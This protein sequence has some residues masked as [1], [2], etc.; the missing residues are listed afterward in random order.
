MLPSPFDDQPGK[1]VELLRF[2]VF[3][4][5]EQSLKAPRWVISCQY[6]YRRTIQDPLKRRSGSYGKGLAVTRTGGYCKLVNNGGL[7][8][9]AAMWVV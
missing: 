1:V 4:L 9:D 8:L 2:Q 3:I 6:E 7:S 5:T